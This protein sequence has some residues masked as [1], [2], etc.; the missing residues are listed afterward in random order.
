M[1]QEAETTARTR[2]DDIKRQLI[3]QGEDEATAERLALS[4]AGVQRGARS[5]A[6]RTTD[7]ELD[8]DERSGSR[9]RDELY[10][11]AKSLGIAG[12]SKMTKAELERAVD[13]RRGRLS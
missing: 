9:T 5:S 3:E 1:P 8:R 7:V 2:F 13:R 10:D 11:E 6:P 4:L 12:R